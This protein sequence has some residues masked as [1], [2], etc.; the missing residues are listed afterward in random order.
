[1]RRRAHCAACLLIAACSPIV[2]RPGVTWHE[3]SAGSPNGAIEEAADEAA[4]AAGHGSIVA[5]TDAGSRELRVWSGFGLQ[6]WLSYVR[7]VEDGAGIRGE[8]V[9]VWNEPAD[10]HCGDNTRQ[11]ADT[12]PCIEL[13]TAGRS[14]ACVL[15]ANSIDWPA[16]L[17]RLERLQIWNLRDGAELG[18]VSGLDGV[19]LAVALRDGARWRRYEWCNPH[20]HADAVHA[21]AILELIERLDPMRVVRMPWDP[22]S[23]VPPPAFCDA[24]EP[25]PRTAEED[26]A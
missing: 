8:H 17:R 19:C 7:V 22:P 24:L 11:L 1:M 13:R 3:G 2:A 16:L 26:S 18:A 12:L 20:G 25:E 5:A 4:A 14:V 10:E 9:L 15:P 21:W 23:K 6:R